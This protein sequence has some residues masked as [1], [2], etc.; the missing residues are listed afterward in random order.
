[1]ATHDNTTPVLKRAH[2][3]SFRNEAALRA[4]EQAGCFHCCEVFHPE[5]IKQWVREHQGGRTAVCP[6]CGI[7]SVLP[8]SAGYPLT[9][10]FL[11]AM[12]AHWFA[13]AE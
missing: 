2:K 3:A 10:E 12:E 8:A 4:S 11:H 9:D 7:D 5:Q 6:R 13:D 1:M